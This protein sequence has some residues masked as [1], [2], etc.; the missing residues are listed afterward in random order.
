MPAAPNTKRS[1]RS[2]YSPHPGILMMTDWVATLKAKTG[3]TLEEWID[4]I[5][6]S[7]PADEA[8]RRDWLK[9][10]HALGT[11]SA[12]WLAER[13]GRPDGAL[14]PDSPEGYMI[15]APRYVDAQYAGKKGALR[16]LY[17]RLLQVGLG[18]GP[19][20]KACPC[21]TM[22]PLYRAHVFAQVKAS[23]NTRIDLGLALAN[24]PDAKIPKRLID[25]GGKAKKDRI[26]HRVPIEK[27]ADID[28]F[29]E[30]WL[31]TAYELDGPT[32]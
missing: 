13:A 7:G 2:P 14:D 18:L 28:G 11:N 1:P 30:K 17:E 16:P 22:V 15:V 25:T 24:V 32:P 27:G 3:R 6:A 31:R 29:V 9:A 20:A 23:T 12:W 8:A 10:R 26:T 5:R 21:Q 4:H 19:D